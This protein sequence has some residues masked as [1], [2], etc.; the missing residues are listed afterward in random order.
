MIP[1][2]PYIL[3]SFVNMKLRDE[4]ADLDSLCKSL[5]IDRKALEEKLGAAGFEYDPSTNQFK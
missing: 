3:L 4:F 1:S 2:D 5:D